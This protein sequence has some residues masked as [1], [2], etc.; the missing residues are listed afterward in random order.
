[1]LVAALPMV[2]YAFTKCGKNFDVISFFVEGWTRIL[3]GIVLALLIS[4]LIAFVPDAENVLAVLGFRSTS[5][6]G[7]GVAIGALLVTGIRGEKT[8]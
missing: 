3:T 4:V 6:W 5:P 2:L 1:M 7:I 8:S